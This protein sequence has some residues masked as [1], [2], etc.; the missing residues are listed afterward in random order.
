[1]FCESDFSDLHIGVSIEFKF[2]LLRADTV[3]TKYTFKVCFKFVSHERKVLQKD[4]ENALQNHRR[5]FRGVF[6]SV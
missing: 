4:L 2:E 3:N 5:I 6:F 1:M